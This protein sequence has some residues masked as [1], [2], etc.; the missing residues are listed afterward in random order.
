MGFTQLILECDNALTVKIILIEG[1]RSIML[2]K[3]CLI[4]QS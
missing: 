2:L 1:M 4:K 3:L